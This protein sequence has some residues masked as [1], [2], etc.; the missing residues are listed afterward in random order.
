[1]RWAGCAKWRVEC[2]GRLVGVVYEKGLGKGV[3]RDGEGE[4]EVAESPGRIED[5]GVETEMCLWGDRV[6]TTSKCFVLT[7]AS[8]RR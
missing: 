8:R 1:M 4:G 5:G 7:V 2:R 3:K 6:K